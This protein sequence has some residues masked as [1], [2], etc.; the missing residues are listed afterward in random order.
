MPPSSHSKSPST[1]RSSSVKDTQQLVGQ[2]SSDGTVDMKEDI[3]YS[4][5]PRSLKVALEAAACSRRGSSDASSET[6]SEEDYDALEHDPMAVVRG[7]RGGGFVGADEPTTNGKAFGKIKAKPSVRPGA[8]R[9][10]SVY[11]CPPLPLYPV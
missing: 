9:L 4:S 7:G 10:R 2:L 5:P 1:S 11:V 6:A 8:P 3:T